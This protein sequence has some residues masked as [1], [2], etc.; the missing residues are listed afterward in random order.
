M[1]NQSMFPVVFNGLIPW[2]A[3]SFLLSLR[4]EVE[5]DP[6]VLD[7][8]FTDDSQWGKDNPEIVDLISDSAYNAFGQYRHRVE[9][10]KHVYFARFNSDD[11]DYHIDQC[12]VNAHSTETDP[13]SSTIN[14]PKTINKKSPDYNKLRPFFGRL[15]ADIIKNTFEH[16]TQYAR[17]PTGTTLRRAFRSPNPALNVVC[18][19][20]IV[21]LFIPIS[22]QL[23]MV[24]LLL[25][26][27]LV[28]TLRK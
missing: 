18:Q 17:L 7:H 6:T 5:W 25:S 15:D 12:V 13:D 16:T 8:A 21:T 23:M 22:L 26:S 2:M 10:N 28:Q 1:T 14:I 4:S 11:I 24:P 3:T 19:N 27:L 20:K 9:V